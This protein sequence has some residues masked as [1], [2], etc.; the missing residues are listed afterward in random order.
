MKTLNKKEL[1]EIGW[2]LLNLSQDIRFAAKFEMK[3]HKTLREHLLKTHENI[4]IIDRI[5]IDGRLMAHRKIA[6][7]MTKVILD[8]DK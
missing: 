1:D 7:I 2:A 6:D 4:D 8:N 3:K 5:L